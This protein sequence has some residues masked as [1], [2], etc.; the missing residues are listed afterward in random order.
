MSFVQKRDIFQFAIS[1]RSIKDIQHPAA[2][3]S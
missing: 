2:L 1:Y 3:S